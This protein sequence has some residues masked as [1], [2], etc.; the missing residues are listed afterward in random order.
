MNI[1]PEI[2]QDLGHRRWLYSDTNNRIKNLE[3]VVLGAL[4]HGNLVSAAVAADYHHAHREP[5]GEGAHQINT[6]T[7]TIGDHLTINA[8]RL[9][10]T[11][12]VRDRRE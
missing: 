9:K 6:V 4:G 10:P 2:L 12:E 8:R 3:V 1:P 5:A 11:V 7:Y